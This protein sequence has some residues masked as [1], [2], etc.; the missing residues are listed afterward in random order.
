MVKTETLR[1]VTT[2]TTMILKTGTY[3]IIYLYIFAGD[4]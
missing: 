2:M 4:F 3:K 1:L